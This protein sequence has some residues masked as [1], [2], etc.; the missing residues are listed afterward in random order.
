M[1]REEYLP[2]PTFLQQVADAALVARNQRSFLLLLCAIVGTIIQSLLLKDR[3]VEALGMYKALAF[4]GLVLFAA[5]VPGIPHTQTVRYIIGVCFASAIGSGRIMY[6]RYLEFHAVPSLEL[7]LRMMVPAVFGVLFL[8][9]IASCCFRGAIHFWTTL[10]CAIAGANA[11]RLAV[12]LVLR[13]VVEPQPTSYPPNLPFGSALLLSTVYIL[14]AAAATPGVRERLASGTGA[15]VVSLRLDDLKESS[16]TGNV[17]EP[18]AAPRSRTISTPTSST[19]SRGHDAECIRQLERTI[20]ELT[21]NNRRVKE[22]L[23]KDLTILSE[24]GALR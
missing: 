24:F 2:S 7:W 5:M 9:V 6:G 22:E 13:W 8:V 21:E 18:S 15:N 12:V 23:K 10:R 19:S 11:C 1:T 16:T 3:I 17:A 14:L 20:E 4:I